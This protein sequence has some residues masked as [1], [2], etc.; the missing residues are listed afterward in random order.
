MEKW[1]RTHKGGKNVGEN[2]TECTKKKVKERIREGEGE[3]KKK[4][5]KRKRLWKVWKRAEGEGEEARCR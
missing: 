4:W 1:V 3:E 5:K 2:N